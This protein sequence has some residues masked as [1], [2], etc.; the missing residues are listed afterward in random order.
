MFG[1]PVRS[2]SRLVAAVCCLALVVA[3]CGSDEPTQRALTTVPQAD[4]DAPNVVVIVTDDQT[5]ES[6]RVMTRTNE[7]LADEGTTFSNFFTPFPLCCPSRTSYLTGQ[8]AFNHGVTDNIGEHG[9]YYALDNRNTLPVWLQRA[10]YATSF[11]GHYLYR[12]GIEDPTEIPPGWDRWF[13]T[14]DPSTFHYYD[15]D[16]NDNGEVVHFGSDAEDY[17]TD[18]MADR[19]VDEIHRLAEGDRPFFLNLW[20]LAP[21]VAEPEHSPLG[22]DLEAVP[23]PRHLHQFDEQWWTTDEAPSFDEADVSDKP[24]FIQGRSRMLPATQIVAQ[25]HYQRALE[26]LL[27]VDE[28][29]ARVVEAL[30]ETG[31]LDDTVIMF[32]SDNGFL[33]GE[34]RIRDAKVLPYE[35]SIHVPLIIRGPGFPVGATAPQLTANIDL[36]PTILELAGVTG[37]LEQDGASLL[38]LV[39]DAD[40]APDDRALYL[41]DGPA[42]HGA[43]IPHYDGVRVPGYTYVEY[44][45]GAREL[46]DLTA[47]PWQLDNLAG[48][49]AYARIEG[50][51]ADLL[52][53]LRGCQGEACREP[54]F[55]SPQ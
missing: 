14:I 31:E 9:G 41:Q 2:S 7:L 24:G 42:D 18:V 35:E 19:T 45:P 46:Y 47:D 51:L 38:P 29:V 8:Y 44:E 43:A 40:P 30:D 49:P 55:T 39:Q 1:R 20:T 53:Q 52:Q 3:A 13:T 50:R 10:G 6:M 34:H 48:D 16:V 17:Q 25:A 33:Q 37:S 36:A 15:Y 22:A 23:A 5:L 27:A 11:V 54:R 12:Y 21:H 28:A 26:S 32:W 4:A